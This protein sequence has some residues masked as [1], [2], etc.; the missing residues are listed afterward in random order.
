[1][2]QELPKLN[3]F[4]HF[5]YHLIDLFDDKEKIKTYYPHFSSFD[6]ALY[7]IEEAYQDGRLYSVEIIPK[8]ERFDNELWVYD[9]TWEPEYDLA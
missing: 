8:N 1:M 4:Q 2:K 5:E 7:E 9:V 6:W 3:E